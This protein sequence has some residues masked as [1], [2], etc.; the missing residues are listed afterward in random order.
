MNLNQANWCF[1]ANIL[2]TNRSLCYFDCYCHFRWVEKIKGEDRSIDIWPSTNIIKFRQKMS[3][4][5]QSKCKS[6]KLA[7][8]AVDD[9]LTCAKL[10]VFSFFAKIMEPCLV[11]YPT[12]NF[13]LS[14]FICS[15]Q[16]DYGS[17]CKVKNKVLSES[18]AA[19]NLKNNWFKWIK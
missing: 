14:R 2:D 11:A 5:K 6:Y 7:Y 4:W 18:S 3:K 13:L 16:K 1:H 10:C 15:S 9:Q 8:D 12:D 19:I 17:R